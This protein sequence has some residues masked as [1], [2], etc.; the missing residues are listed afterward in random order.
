[1]NKIVRISIPVLLATLFLGIFLILMGVSRQAQASNTQAALQGG[2]TRLEL[3]VNT[4]ED[5]LDSDGDCSFR[6]AVAA[7]NTNTPID[8]CP[9][10]SVDSQ[11]RI[12]FSAV[13]R[14]YLSATITITN[15]G[16]LYIDG[17]GVEV[18]DGNGS[19]G[20]LNVKDGAKLSLRGL[21]VMNGYAFTGAGIQN[22][23]SLTVTQCTVTYNVGTE[24]CGIYNSGSLR[25][26]NSL[27][28]YNFDA[29]AGGGVGIYQDAGS[30]EIAES[31]IMSNTTYFGM[32]GGMYIGI[33]SEMRISDSTIQAN[34]GGIMGGGILNYGSLSIV[35]SLIA[36]NTAYRH[37]FGFGGGIRNDGIASISSTSFFHN[38]AIGGGGISNSGGALVISGC[39][40]YSNTA[41]SAGAVV[42]SGLLTVLN[43]TLSRNEAVYNGGL[44]NIGQATITNTTFFSNRS[45]EHSG[46]NITNGSGTLSLHNSIVAGDAI[47]N[48]V[49][50][51]IDA[52][53][54]LESADTCGF[55][56]TNGS[57]V[58]T[59]PLLGQLQA[60]GGPT[61]THALLAGSPAINAGSNEGCPP[62]D[63][64]GIARP[65]LGACDIGAFE[66]T[67]TVYLPMAMR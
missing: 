21:H 64:R 47:T 36:D 44:S 38:G 58:N 12:T 50:T 49:G 2:K 16:P 63:Q 24:G 65:A 1:M 59:D 41:T 55:S 6:E 43:S 45:M 31:V 48:C 14:I 19:V 39:T 18:L 26:L 62:I 33:G 57:L 28:A 20:V 67:L 29:D 4:L 11:D 8:N 46:W 35:D 13:G 10:G 60:N 37:G 51:I 52:G 25:V 66:Y 34:N 7:A 9:A 27:I 61:W 56:P 40:F 22:S 30:V 53:Y 3:I 42:N 5:E 54:N 17:G 23:G 32:G 15:G